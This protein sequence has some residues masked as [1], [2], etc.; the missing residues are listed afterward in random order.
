MYLIL[1]SQLD[2]LMEASALYERFEE[3]LN[4]IL[5]ILNSD[6]D[7]ERTPFQTAL[8]LEIKILCTVLNTTGENFRFMPTI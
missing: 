2:K 5:E 3:N 7:L 6:I 4:I 1:I 8:P